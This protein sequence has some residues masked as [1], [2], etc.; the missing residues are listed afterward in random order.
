MTDKITV[1]RELLE[2]ITSNNFFGS[3]AIDE[4]RAALSAPAQDELCRHGSD[5]GCKQCYV[6]EQAAPVQ[7]QEPVGEFRVSEY[8]GEPAFYWVD[9]IPPLGTK[10]YTHPSPADTRLVEALEHARL[11]IVNGI[12]LGY[13][14]M[15]DVDT[16]DPAHDTLPMI[17]AALA[18]HKG[19]PT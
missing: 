3:S 19:E 17:E 18:T 1:D 14:K 6:E 2:R 5:Y 13:I 11:F 7:Q 15:P 9:E 12:D 10:L 8:D 16:P 4:L